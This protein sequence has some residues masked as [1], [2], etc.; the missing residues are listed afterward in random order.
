MASDRLASGSNISQIKIWDT[1]TGRC[2]QTLEGQGY[3]YSVESVA[4]SATGERLASGSWDG[5]IKI[6]ETASGDCAWRIQGHSHSIKSV[7]FAESGD[8][9]ASGSDDCTIKIWNTATGGCIQTLT[10]GTSISHLLFDPTSTY[11]LTEIGRSRVDLLPFPA[12]TSQARDMT[13]TRATAPVS[14]SVVHYTETKV[15]GYGLSPDHIWIARDGQNF[16]WLPPE[17]RPMC[18]A[19][20]GQMVAIGCQSGRV[21]IFGFSPDAYA[22]GN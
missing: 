9:L 18:S 22:A 13:D 20:Q 14:D 17:F 2:M 1:V 7:A 12:V 11:L 21:L 5:V 3:D 19:V 8:D 16:L 6:W 4:F 10:I 15:Y